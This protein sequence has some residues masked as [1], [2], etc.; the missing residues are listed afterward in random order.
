MS[1]DLKIL[2]FGWDACVVVESTYGQIKEKYSSR[3]RDGGAF[4]CGNTPEEAVK[5]LISNMRKQ[6]TLIEEA[7]KKGFD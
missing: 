1:Q 5:S 3:L 7:L 2:K 4:G 6:A